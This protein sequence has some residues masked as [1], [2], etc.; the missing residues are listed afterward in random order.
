MERN[1]IKK[2]MT[3]RELNDLFFK[4]WADDRGI[5]RGKPVT[6]IYRMNQLAGKDGM[7]SVVDE[8]ILAAELKEANLTLA[9]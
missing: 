2:N 6:L 4:T 5:I 9:K 7:N 1:V 8:S 3:Y